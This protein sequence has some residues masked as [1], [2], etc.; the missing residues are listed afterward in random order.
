MADTAKPK[1][2]KKIFAFLKDAPQPQPAL[3]LD[4]GIKEQGKANGDNDDDDL[5]LFKR[6]K[7]FFPQVVKEQEEQLRE[8][9]SPLAKAVHR[10]HDSGDDDDDRTPSPPRSNKR[11]KLSSTPEN[12][13]PWR[14]STEDLYGKPTPPRHVSKSPSPW[15][16]EPDTEEGTPPYQKPNKS[17]RSTRSKTRDSVDLV[18]SDVLPTPRRSKS[19]HTPAREAIT[20]DDDDPFE[21]DSPGERPSSPSPRK[22]SVSANL[23]PKKMPTT[24]IIHLGSDDDDDETTGAAPDP[25]EDP[26]SHLIDRAKKQKQAAEA[27][28]AALAKFEGKD[29]VDENGNLRK[30]MM[31]VVKIFIYSRLDEAP[32]LKPFGVKRGIAQDL[33]F[34]RKHFV[35]WARN[36]GAPIS[37]EQADRICL[38]WKG[39]Q[40]YDSSTGLSLQWPTGDFEMPACTPGFARNGILLEAW[41]EEG[42]KWHTAEI[43]KEKQRLIDCDEL[44]EEDGEAEEVEEAPQA[45]KLKITLK[46][47]D[48]EPLKLSAHADL[49]VKLLMTTYRRMRNIPDDRTIRLRNE[50]EWMDPQM[51]LEQSDVEDMCTIEVYL[52]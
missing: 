51:T 30:K 35:Q 5:N 3:N 38:T 52:K 8:A 29:A 48:A 25:E 15:R 18:Q 4:D 44:P 49:L 45:P 21:A 31:P 23:T 11:R 47:K 24:E 50:G 37:E 2:K 16:E 42:F 1:K 7:D 34:V 22:G 9:A 10:H 6:A 39:R 40:I 26:F 27:A 28:A 14:E 41:T 46:E 32:A 13:C 19:N 20:L 12:K 36:Q 43:E 17:T 33:G